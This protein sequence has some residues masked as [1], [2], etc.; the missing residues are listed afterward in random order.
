VLLVV[1]LLSQGVTISVKSWSQKGFHQELP[2]SSVAPGTTL[3]A[4]PPGRRWDDYKDMARD[5]SGS[6][7]ASSLASRRW[8]G[9]LE[10]LQDNHACSLL[11]DADV[12]YEF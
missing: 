8:T 5:Y 12:Y 4:A 7:A 3:S 9:Q 6:D 2:G 11:Q 10:A 1:E